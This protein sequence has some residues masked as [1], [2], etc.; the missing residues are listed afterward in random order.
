M[1]RVLPLTVHTVFGEVVAKMNV[2]SPLVAV[3][4]SVIG[5]TPN[6]TGE[7]GANVTVCV[8]ELIRTLCVTCVA[9]A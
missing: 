2:V 1:V 4:V 6:V 8:A 9:A 7:E 5:A 3:A